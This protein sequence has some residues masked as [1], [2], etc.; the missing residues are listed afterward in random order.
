VLLKKAQK[1]PIELEQNE[2]GSSRWV[3]SQ[4]GYQKKEKKT[5]EL[6]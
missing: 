4:L 1:N 3:H 5:L 6:S 2:E